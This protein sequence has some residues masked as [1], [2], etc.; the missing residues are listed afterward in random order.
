MWPTPWGQNRPYGMADGVQGGGPGPVMWPHQWGVH[1]PPKQVKC[2]TPQRAKRLFSGRALYRASAY[3]D[4]VD[5][6]KT[7][8][9]AAVR[10]SHGLWSS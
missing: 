5:T 6:D 7:L 10:I 3:S 2:R 4:G 1:L 8:F 9:H